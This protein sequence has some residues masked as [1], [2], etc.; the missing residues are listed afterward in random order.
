MELISG[1]EGELSGRSFALTLQVVGDPDAE[2]AVYRR[3]WS[4][5]RVDGVFACDLR[6]A[7]RR[8]AVLDELRLPA[9][10]VAGPG[11]FGDRPS[12]WSDEATSIA[13]TVR[14]LVALGH[15]HIAR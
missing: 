8:L 14:Y 12:V 15:R 13:E 1:L 4:E 9:V 5:R 3:W 10:V 2:I 7:D 11:D 6:V